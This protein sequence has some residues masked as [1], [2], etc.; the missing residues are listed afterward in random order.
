[1]FWSNAGFVS[2]EKIH[3]VSNHFNFLVKLP[4]LFFVYPF[5]LLL[6]GGAQ[7]VSVLS[8]LKT[9]RYQDVCVRTSYDTAR[10]LLLGGNQ[11]TQN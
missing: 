9:R 11:D 2:L 10:G 7:F 4:Q 5:M 6:E 3:L 1:M 8:T